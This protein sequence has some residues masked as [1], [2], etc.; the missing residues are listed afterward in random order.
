MRHITIIAVS[1]LFPFISH[2]ATW[3]QVLEQNGER[4]D[5][6]I[7]SIV[8]HGSTTEVWFRS[9]F[10]TPQSLPG[11]DGLPLPLSY[12]SSLGFYVMD[13]EAR[14]EA[15]LQ[16][17]DYDAAGNKVYSSSLPLSSAS[18]EHIIPDSLGEQMFNVACRKP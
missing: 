16:I 1:A 6:D 17:V 9:T 14:T 12:S 7:S 3:R 10:N 4:I 2:A 11:R 18:L 15:L 13:C 8:H 5:M